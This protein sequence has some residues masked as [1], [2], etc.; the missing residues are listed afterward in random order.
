M[1]VKSA[2]SVD[3]QRALL[4]VAVSL[5]ATELR[6]INAQVPSVE[7]P[8]T[9]YKSYK[10]FD[11]CGWSCAFPPCFSWEYQWT[12]TR[13][14]G[15]WEGGDVLRFSTADF[16]ILELSLKIVQDF[17]SD[18]AKFDKIS[19]CVVQAVN[20]PEIILY[21]DAAGR[22]PDAQAEDSCSTTDA[23]VDRA[24]YDFAH[25][26][27][28]AK[29]WPPISLVP[30]YESPVN[31]DQDLTAYAVGFVDDVQRQNRFVNENDLPNTFD[32]PQFYQY[33]GDKLFI[34]LNRAYI[35]EQSK[36]AQA[37]WNPQLSGFDKN[38][39]CDV[40]G[41]ISSF[42]SC[43]H[44]A[45]RYFAGTLVHEFLHL[46]G[47]QHH[48]YGAHTSESYLHQT[49][50]YTV[51]DCIRTWGDF[52]GT[53]NSRATSDYSFDDFFGFPEEV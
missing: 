38:Q 35:D 15:Y 20:Y 23:C 4:L 28:L 21:T 33:W 50:I 12:C 39:I 37:C 8:V 46:M 11:E 16:E 49:F 9:W 1:R 43:K 18:E 52:A 14:P 5:S 2:F 29:S 40:N 42:S 7:I 25:L 31:G 45:A 36:V 27:R 41:A 51:G 53:R 34:N 44:C 48:V 19:E 6:A 3:L 26:M 30:F 47:H 17:T 10:S 13:N 22:V 32:Y 24:I